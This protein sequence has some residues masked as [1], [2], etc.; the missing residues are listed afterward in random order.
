M[1]FMYT[2]CSVNLM[3]CMMSMTNLAKKRPQFMTQ[4]IEG[5]ESL[6]GKFSVI[7][8]VP[9][10]ISLT[11]NDDKAN[12]LALLWPVLCFAYTVTTAV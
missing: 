11:Q 9:E 10:H 5:F 4:V 2:T 8:Q 6:H 3:A 7:R 12:G 1:I